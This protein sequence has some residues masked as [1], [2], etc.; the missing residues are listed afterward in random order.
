MAAPA[1]ILTTIRDRPRD[2][3]ARWVILVFGAVVVLLFLAAW[4]TGQSDLP[5]I[6]L[7]LLTPLLGGVLGLSRL[8]RASLVAHERTTIVYLLMCLALLAWGASGLR[9][10][11]EEITHRGIALVPAWGD[12]GFLASGLLWAAAIWVLYEGVVTDFLSQV[13]KNAFLISGMTLATAFVL[14]VAGGGDLIEAIKAGGNPVQIV[15][16]VC[17]V[18]F[19]FNVVMLLR[20]VHGEL[21]SQ[22]AAGRRALTIIVIGLLLLYVA[23]LAFETTVTLSQR[24]TGAEPVY[25]NVQVPYFLYAVAFLVLSLGVVGYPLETSVASRRTTPT[26]VT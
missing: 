15:G 20:L 11:V 14:S 4:A 19:G 25:Q 21:G 2:T 17:P 24:L 3:V 5:A 10:A 7:Y 6:N 12:L 18:L 16:L 13:E 9:D 22:R 8:S 1:S 23:E 26:T